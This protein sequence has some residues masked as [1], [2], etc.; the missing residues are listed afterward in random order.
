VKLGE[1]YRRGGRIVGA[2]WVKD[3]IRNPT[4]STNLSP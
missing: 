2:I 4:E 1:F 3:I